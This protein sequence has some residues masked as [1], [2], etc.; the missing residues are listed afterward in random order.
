M[1]AH[2]YRGAGLEDGNYLEIFLD[3]DLGGPL[4]FLSW[5]RWTLCLPASYVTFSVAFISSA[6]DDGVRANFEDLR[7]SSESATLRLSLFVMSCIFGPFIWEPSSGIAT[8]PP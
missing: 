6:Y 1:L 4:Q 3:N 7:A 8:C 2:E 5:L